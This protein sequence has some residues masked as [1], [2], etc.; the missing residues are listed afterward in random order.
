MIATLHHKNVKGFVEKHVL[1]E[2]INY[3]CYETEL[4]F[5]GPN[6]EVYELCIVCVLILSYESN[7]RSFYRLKSIN[8]F[9][10]FN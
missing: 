8:P 10:I 3:S 6:T 7:T 4:D 1:G 2:K 5:I 9:I